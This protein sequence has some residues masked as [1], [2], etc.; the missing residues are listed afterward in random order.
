MVIAVKKGWHGNGKKFSW[1]RVG[2]EF[3]NAIWALLVPVII[4]GGIY[5]G[6]F[7]PTEAAVV[8]VIYALIIGLFVYRELDLKRIWEKLFDSA[9]TTG[10]ILII[11][12]TGTVLGRVF[13]LENAPT[14][15]ADALNGFTDSRWVILAIITVILLIVGCL[16]ETT[17]A[18]LILGPILCPILASYG[19]SPVH[20]GL[21]MVVNLS[22][23]FITP[24]VG[25]NLFVACGIGNLKF[26]TLVRNI[27]PF[28]T[29]LL[30]A[31]LLV[32]YI[33]PISMLLP[34]LLG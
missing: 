27:V 22:I 24:P 3:K 29:A 14:M 6:I 16:M 23:G 10:T 21:I 31:L 20:F 30:V 2:V 13:T 8:A 9:K 34:N 28:L 12:A 4:L 25:A 11:V 1:K 5:G 26:Q 33:A 17:S 15:I 18:I 32:T 19:V 7:T